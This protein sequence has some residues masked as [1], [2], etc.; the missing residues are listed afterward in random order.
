M[1]MCAMK[2]NLGRHVGRSDM[3][4]YHDKAIMDTDYL[5][6]RNVVL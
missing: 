3:T 4:L 5:H 1:F 6:L 2:L